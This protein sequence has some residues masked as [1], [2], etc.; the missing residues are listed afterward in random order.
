[1]LGFKSRDNRKYFLVLERWLKRGGGGEREKDLGI[2]I[3]V[4]K[5]V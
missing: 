1:M 2:K 4:Y 5:D 3:I